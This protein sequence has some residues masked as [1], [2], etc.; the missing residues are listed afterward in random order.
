[1]LLRPEIYNRMAF[2]VDGFHMLFLFSGHAIAAS[3]PNANGKVA[4]SCSL[5]LARV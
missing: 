1:M 5:G 3:K 4:S 2:E